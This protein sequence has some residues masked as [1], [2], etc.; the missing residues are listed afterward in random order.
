MLIEKWLKY[1]T[2]VLKLKKEK[3]EK[4]DNNNMKSYSLS[5]ST[6]CEWLSGDLL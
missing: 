3:M 6:Y 2:R 4:S 5:I 1:L